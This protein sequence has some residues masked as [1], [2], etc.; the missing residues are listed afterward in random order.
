MQGPTTVTPKASIGTDAAT[1]SE[2]DG[3]LEPIF[4]AVRSAY[5]A[6]P[7]CEAVYAQYAAL[8]GVIV[9]S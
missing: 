8:G 5:Y 4:T 7:L 3:L 6:Q 1:V 9:D 2:L